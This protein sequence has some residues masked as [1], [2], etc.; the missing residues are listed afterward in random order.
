MANGHASTQILINI[1]L[2]AS[3]V[4]Q[5]SRLPDNTAVSVQPEELHALRA[6]LRRGCTDDSGGKHT[7]ALAHWEQFLRTRGLHGDPYMTRV[8]SV[9]EQAALWLLYAIELNDGPRKLRGDQVQREL[10]LLKSNW[11]SNFGDRRFFR[12]VD[13]DVQA[14]LRRAQAPTR[15]HASQ[16]VIGRQ[17]RAK[18]PTTPEFFTHFVA[19]LW[20]PTLAEG[21]RSSFTPGLLDSLGAHLGAMMGY[22][23]GCR[24][25]N[26]V[27]GN[28]KTEDKALHTG[29]LTFVVG[30]GAGVQRSM[31]GTE[32]NA[33]SSLVSIGRI[34]FNLVAT[35]V[36]RAV[37]EL[38]I[39]TV[40]EHER[41]L[42]HAVVAWIRV[43]GTKDDD[44]L[45]TRYAKGKGGAVGRRL[46]TRKDVNDV[47]KLTAG[48]L[49]LNPGKFSSKSFRVGI[50]SSAGLSDA[51]KDQV[52][53]WKAG[54]STR[55][56][57]YDVRDRRGRLSGRVTEDG[58]MLEWLRS[59]SDGTTQG[60]AD[61]SEDSDSD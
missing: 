38:C 60:V 3:V 41:R 32:I 14:R 34:Q 23:F 44:P 9:H 49:G 61:S 29:D 19:E 46:T 55:R 25:G 4:D 11:V 56:D 37:E 50:A 5:P 51:R 36:G 8:P 24:I 17:A 54:G 26:L 45:L 31:R 18:W 13:G 39:S 2:S 7:A 43:S 22:N 28:L 57:H 20:D 40:E 47:I 27:R 42:L 59:R 21:E 10:S 48:Q 33:V 35:K 52:A 15:E 53:G 30:G 58:N 16:V 6:C 12:L 1:V